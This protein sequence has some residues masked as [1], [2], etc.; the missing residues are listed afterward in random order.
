[1]SKL[2]ETTMIKEM[3]LPNRF[4]R[5]ATWEGMAKDDGAC[6]PRLTRLMVDLAEALKTAPGLY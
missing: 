6:T 4:V 5:S 2:F 1:M 3:T